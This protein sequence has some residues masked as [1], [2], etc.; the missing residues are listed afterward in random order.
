M[1]VDSSTF[2]DQTHLREVRSAGNSV[3]SVWV[4]DT[5]LGMVFHR[6]RKP[7]RGMLRSFRCVVH[8]EALLARFISR[9]DLP[10]GARMYATDVGGF[11]RWNGTIWVVEGPFT[12][13][14]SSASVATP[15]VTQTN[16]Q[17]DP[18][19]NPLGPGAALPP[20]FMQLGRRFRWSS[21]VGRTLGSLESAITQVRIG[22]T[23]IFSA[24]WNDANMHEQ[25]P[26]FE[27]WVSGVNQITTKGLAVPNS[28]SN[29]PW[30]TDVAVPNLLTTPGN[31]I[32]G[33]KNPTAGVTT[34]HYSLV[35]A[36]VECLD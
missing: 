27:F 30:T 32:I 6:L 22:A 17:P 1:T 3:Y 9:T 14:A 28:A 34:E 36:L 7:G 21:T 2:L 20:G 11:F 23:A 19:F 35:D 24:P 10:V 18:T 8:G 15:L 13:I 26:F 5:G 4:D 31:L 16:L 12:L 29:T 25:Y 33:I